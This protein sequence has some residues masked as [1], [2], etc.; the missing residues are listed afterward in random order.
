MTATAR[1]VAQRVEIERALKEYYPAA[2]FTY[3]DIFTAA[4]EGRRIGV[5]MSSVH[6]AIKE[7]VKRGVLVRV[8]ATHHPILFEWSLAPNAIPVT[9]WGVG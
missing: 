2:R 8:P 5:P 9:G 1:T 3:H 6:I 7:L 4:N